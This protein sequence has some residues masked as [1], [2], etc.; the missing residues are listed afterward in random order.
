MNSSFVVHEVHVRIEDE[1]QR[2]YINNRLVYAP[3]MST[4]DLFR[5]W[6]FAIC[7]TQTAAEETLKNKL[8]DL[9]GA[10]RK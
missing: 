5:Q 8:R 9:L 6:G 7:N 1:G 10:A 2:V 3:G 4:D